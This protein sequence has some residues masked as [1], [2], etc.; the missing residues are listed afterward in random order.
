MNFGPIRFILDIPNGRAHFVGSADGDVHISVNE[1][2]SL[3]TA[4]FSI[5]NVTSMQ[6]LMYHLW[7][8]ENVEEAGL[9]RSNWTQFYRWEETYACKKC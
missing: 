7:F 6:S 4:H 9:P 1:K 3:V 2:T 5:K 8:I